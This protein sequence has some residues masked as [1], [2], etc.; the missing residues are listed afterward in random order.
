[1]SIVFKDL[2]QSELAKDLTAFLGPLQPKDAELACSCCSCCHSHPFVHVVGVR[3]C[4]C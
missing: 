4:V 3:V 2:D 1:M